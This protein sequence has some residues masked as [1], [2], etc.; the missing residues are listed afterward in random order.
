MK[1]QVF[2]IIFG[3]GFFLS[4]VGPRSCDDVLD[5]A[6]ALA[7]S[8]GDS[9]PKALSNS[10]IIEGL[11]TALK[12]GTDS[13]VSMTSRNNGFYK[14]EAIKILLPPEAKIIYDNKDKA[15][16]KALKLDQKLEEAVMALNRAAEDAAKEAGPIFKD[17]I[18]GMSVSDGLSIL[19]GSNPA[20]AEMSSG[21]DSTAA[22]GYLQS[23]T[24]ENLHIAFTPIINASLDKKL[25]GNYSANQIWN[26]LSS[27][28]NGIADKS[29][30]MIEP[31]NNTS[32]G[33]YVCD[34]ALDG[35]FLKVA[36]EEIQ[37]RQNPLAWAKTA[38]GNILAKIFG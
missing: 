23:T 38:V 3:L 8:S 10:E 25:M 5:T 19:R 14:D 29:F 34:K 27:G 1:N 11:K 16:L 24:R 36:E 30:G 26:T 32:L 7:T 22:T 15:L 18:V 20:A 17:A 6:I 35:L 37:I 9:G 2:L 13:S 31:M 28:Y 33:S 21:F 4:P 12:V